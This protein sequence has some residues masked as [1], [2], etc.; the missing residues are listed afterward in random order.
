MRIRI[1]SEDKKYGFIIPNSLVLSRLGAKILSK[2][3][4]MRNLPDIKGKDMRL[5]RKTVKEMKKIH[6]DWCL[7]DFES[8]DGERVTV[9]F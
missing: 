2:S 3:K 8:A 5:L 7:V 6:S 9:K 4:G 1:T